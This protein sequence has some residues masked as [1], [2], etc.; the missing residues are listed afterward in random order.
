MPRRRSSAAA[1]PKTHKRQQLSSSSN[2][3]RAVSSSSPGAGGV[4]ASKRLRGSES[5]SAAGK[6]RAK[7]S[8]TAWKDWE[9]T[10][11]A[12]SEKISEVDAT[13]PELPA[14]DLVRASLE[15]VFR[16]YR[17]VRFS[18]DQTPYKVE[19]W[20]KGAIRSVHVLSFS[21]HRLTAMLTC[22]DYVQIGPDGQS[23]VGSGLWM[24]EAP[25]LGI[26]RND[27]DQNPGR[28]RSILTEPG[29]RKHIFDGVAKDEKKAIQAFTS[30]NGESALKT[31][32]KA[33]MLKPD[34]YAA[35][36]P[37]IE[38]LRLR[39]FTMGK[40]LSEAEVLAPNALSRITE[41]IAVMV[42][43]VS[44]RPALDLARK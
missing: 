3:T 30:H 12:L 5:E 25:R 44:L 36:N 40:R 32:P 15:Q 42:P 38:L 23:Y 22:A 4:R 18:K 7:N 16:I 39:S 8:R 27:I 37:N 1:T 33:S 2:H 31:R 26:L 34:G 10:V 24:P 21:S 11:E 13:V 20:E 17:D 35:D 19:N 14:K 29:I 6:A 43:F 9:S 41:L 28:L